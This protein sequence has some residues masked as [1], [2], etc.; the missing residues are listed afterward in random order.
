MILYDNELEVQNE[1]VNPDLPMSQP[2]VETETNDALMEVTNF[3]GVR[4]MNDH[5]QKGSDNKIAAREVFGEGATF[6][7]CSFVFHR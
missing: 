2:E 3:G 7:N 4:T 5:C 1:S 6:Q